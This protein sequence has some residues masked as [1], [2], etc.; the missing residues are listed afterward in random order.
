MR[1]PAI[2][3][4]RDNTLIVGNEYLGDPA[5]VVLVAG[6]ANVVARAREMGFATVV[7]SNQSGVARGMFTE[8]DVRAVNRKMDQM[9]LADNPHAVIDRHEYCPFHPD[10]K[11]ERYKQDSVLRKPRPGMI[12]VA[13][14][15]MA[16]DLKRS[17]MIGDAPRD[18]AAGKAAGCRTIL[19]VDPTL[20]VSPAATEKGGPAAD[21]TVATLVEAMNIV[22]RDAA[23]AAPAE[24]VTPARDSFRMEAVEPGV[25]ID[26]SRL[27]QLTQQV[28]VEVRRLNDGKVQDDFSISKLTAGIMQMLAVMSVLAGYF[29][30]REDQS[31]LMIMLL[32]AIFLQSFTIALLIMGKQK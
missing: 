24:P 32:L 10:A 6:A 7:V 29:L 19:I 27:E 15:A 16:L 31:T 23:T 9:L 21:F 25:K 3:F 14:E 5:K 11:V 8:D 18:V 1:R 28:V 12:L 4:D 2:F 13:A 17:W 22:I 20:P 30:Y 26:L